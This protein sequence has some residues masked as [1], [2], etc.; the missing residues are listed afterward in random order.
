VPTRPMRQIAHRAESCST[1]HVSHYVT[2]NRERTELLQEQPAWIKW[3]NRLVQS[4]SGFI[5]FGK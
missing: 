2:Q 5:G 3:A 4:M 1:D